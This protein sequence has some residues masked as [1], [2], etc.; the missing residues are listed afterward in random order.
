[1][2]DRDGGRR[3]DRLRPHPAR[4]PFRWRTRIE[5]WD[6]G[7]RFVD[8][9]V[10]GLFSLWEHI[11]TFDQR[12]GGTLIHDRVLYRTPYGPLGTAQASMML[13]GLSW[14]P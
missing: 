14:P 7:R 11:H 10:R 1:V 5:L 2:T 9:Q 13:D 12:D 4:I 8:V 3:A 6:P